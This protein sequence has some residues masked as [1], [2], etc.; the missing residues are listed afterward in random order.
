MKH[1]L[2][3]V[4]CCHHQLSSPLLP[5]AISAPISHLRRQTVSILCRIIASICCSI[6]YSIIVSRVRVGVKVW[7][8]QRRDSLGWSCWRDNTEKR[9]AG[10]RWG[11]G[12]RR[13]RLLGLRRDRERYL[14][15]EKSGMSRWCG[16]GFF[17]VLYRGI[18]FWF[19]FENL[20][21]K[22]KHD[23]VRI[24]RNRAWPPSPKPDQ[25]GSVRLD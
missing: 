18:R 22:P 19:G 11:S 12:K 5:S 8:G 6:C 20:K 16:L 10:S 15:R 9:R 24:I 7:W 25:T 3:G 13:G 2:T 23:W 17:L 1:G 21:P 14:E 4:C